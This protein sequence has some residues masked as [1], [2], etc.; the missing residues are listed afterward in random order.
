MAHS[1][2]TGPA[3]HRFSQPA[4][5]ARR[6]DQAK[7]GPVAKSPLHGN[8]P[9]RLPQADTNTMGGPPRGTLHGAK[10]PPSDKRGGF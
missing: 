3:A 6:H 8:T 2:T 5:D 1:V 4:A 7:E 10:L 9:A